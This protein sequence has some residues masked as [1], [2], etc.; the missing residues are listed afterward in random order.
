M[1]DTMELVG[2][3]AAY[4]KSLLNI[5]ETSLFCTSQSSTMGDRPS[6]NPPLCLLI[7]FVL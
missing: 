3:L 1:M 6:G 5:V 7:M 2:K 4:S